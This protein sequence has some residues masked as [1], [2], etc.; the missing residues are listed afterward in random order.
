[1]GAQQVETAAGHVVEALIGFHPRQSKGRSA[2]EGEQVAG[3]AKEL[4]D[5]L[6]RCGLWYWRMGGR[7]LGLLK[8]TGQQARDRPYA[9]LARLSARF[10]SDPVAAV[11]TPGFATLPFA[12]GSNV[13]QRC[14]QVAQI[15]GLTPWM[16]TLGPDL[17][18]LRAHAGLLVAEPGQNRP[19]QVRERL[20]KGFERGLVLRSQ[21]ATA[22]GEAAGELP[23]APDGRLARLGRH[24]VEGHEQ[25]AVRRGDLGHAVSVLPLVARQKGQRDLLRQVAPMG[26]RPGD[27]GRP[28]GVHLS[29]GGVVL[30]APPAKAHDHIVPLG[31]ARKRHPVCLGGAQAQGCTLTRRVGTATRSAGYREDATPGL[32]GL[33][34]C[35]RVAQHQQ[36]TAVGTGEACGLLNDTRLRVS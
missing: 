2:F 21:P 15:M 6:I 24:A 27:V 19:L 9:R 23:D 36:V 18:P 3:V 32:H 10:C 16:A 4:R 14:G 31:S 1:V 13:S 8:R 25:A 12:G 5:H 26:L 28:V 11:L 17:G 33:G 34:P 29:G 35:E 7:R 22:S 30:L 20:Q